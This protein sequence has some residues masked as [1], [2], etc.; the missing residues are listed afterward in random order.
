MPN[1]NRRT[2][3]T[4]LRALADALRRR[5]YAEDYKNYM[6]GFIFYKYLSAKLEIY[7]NTKLLAR[8]SYSFADMLPQQPRIFE[9]GKILNRI[10]GAIQRLFDIF[11]R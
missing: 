8:E 7:C 11:E 10:K 9:R 6:L 5:M 4:Q 1:E 3:V 2:F